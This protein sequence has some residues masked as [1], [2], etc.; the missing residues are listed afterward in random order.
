M[1]S[2]TA[3]KQ[4]SSHLSY[5]FLP[6]SWGDSFKGNAA[7]AILFVS[8]ELVGHKTSTGHPCSHMHLLLQGFKGAGRADACQSAVSSSHEGLASFRGQSQVHTDALKSD[9]SVGRH[10]FKLSSTCNGTGAGGS[11]KTS[12]QASAQSEY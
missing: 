8:S 6:S 5:L 4:I 3:T 1:F 12:V 2:S 9:Y 10:S 7:H 11:K